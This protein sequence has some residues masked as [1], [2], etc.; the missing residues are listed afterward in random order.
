M[1]YDLADLKF[2]VAESNR[3]EGIRRA[4]I[5]RELQAH[6]DLLA[7][8]E[9]SVINVAKFVSS[10]Q[11]GAELRIRPGMNVRVGSHIAPAGGSTVGHGLMIIINR[12]MNRENPWDIHVAYETLHPFMDGNGRSGR[13]IWLWQ[14]LHQ[15]EAPWAL[16]MGFLHL[17]YYQT[18]S[19]V[20]RVSDDASNTR[21]LIS[22][23]QNP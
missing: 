5:K 10:I 19:G 2:F 13:A 8:P 4:P 7:L 18:L 20:G 9:L 17:W 22:Q 1:T 12:V 6:V 23:A 16:R 3:I 21:P 15:Q 11:P 14:M